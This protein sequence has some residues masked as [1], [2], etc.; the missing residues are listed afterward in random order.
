MTA[1]SVHDNIYQHKRISIKCSNMPKFLS[2][3]ITSH[4]DQKKTEPYC[5]EDGPVN[6]DKFLS[7]EIV[8]DVKSCARTRNSTNANTVKF[9]AYSSFL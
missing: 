1:N 2:K 4:D 3:L 9:L 5:F 7:N 6:D 8:N